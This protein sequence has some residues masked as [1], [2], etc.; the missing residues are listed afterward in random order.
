MPGAYGGGFWGYLAS[1]NYSFLI[2]YNILLTLFVVCPSG[3][4]QIVLSLQSNTILKYT[5]CDFKGR[6]KNRE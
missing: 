1:D 6:E 2:F 5:Q 4:F 3:L